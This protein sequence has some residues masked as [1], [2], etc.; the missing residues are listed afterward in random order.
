[1]KFASVYCVQKGGKQ[2]GKYSNQASS[3]SCVR[4]MCTIPVCVNTN[5]PNKKGEL[6]EGS[7]IC[8]KKINQL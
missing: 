6:F 1:M 8:I 2:Q 3:K 4:K 5:A 7:F